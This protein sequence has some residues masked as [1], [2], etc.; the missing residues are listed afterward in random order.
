[1]SNEHSKLSDKERAAMVGLRLWNGR[2]HGKFMSGHLYVAARSKAQAQ[3]L[4]RM[5]PGCNYMSF[6]REISEYYS[7][8][9]WGDSMKGIPVSIGVWATTKE[10][11]TP[12][13]IVTGT[14]DT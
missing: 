13:Q 7:A 3:R 10:N 2:G 6:A 12:T 11:R 4:L 8:D 9:C 14:K 5:V 1:M